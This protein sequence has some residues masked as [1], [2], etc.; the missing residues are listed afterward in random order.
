[1]ELQ[2]KIEPLEDEISDLKEAN[3]ERLEGKEQNVTVSLWYV[4]M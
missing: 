4:V 2:K 1:M 3:A